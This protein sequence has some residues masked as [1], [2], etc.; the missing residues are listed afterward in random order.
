MAV[1]FARESGITNP[2]KHKGMRGS[3]PAA[4]I[5]PIS[6]AVI[7]G[8]GGSPQGRGG[9]GGF[10]KSFASELSGGGAA[11]ENSLTFNATQTVQVTV[12]A[13]AAT[14][15]S[16][17]SPSVLGTITSLGGGRGGTATQVGISG[18][19]GGGGGGGGCYGYDGSN[20]GAGTAGQ[21]FAGSQGGPGGVFNQS[22]TTGGGGIGGGAGGVGGVGLATLMR[23]SSETFASGSTSLATNTGNAGQSG[24]V[25][26]RYPNLYT[27]TVGAGL[28]GTTTTVG[29]DKVTSITAGTGNISWTY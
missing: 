29:N 7:A 21:G 3:N 6:F 13:G 28:T 22:C 14:S 16:N 15:G 27:I 10:R 11:S 23:G 1:Q 12:G 9:A 17:G 20:G 25:I 8:G 2:I 19:S 4:S 18:G 5:G 24:I 26:V